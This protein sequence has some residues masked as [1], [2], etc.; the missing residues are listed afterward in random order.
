VL[1]D[2]DRGRLFQLFPPQSAQDFAAT[3]A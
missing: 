1:G 2:F 3:I